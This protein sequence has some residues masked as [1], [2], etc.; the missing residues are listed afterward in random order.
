MYDLVFVVCMYLYFFVFFLV[1]NSFLGNNIFILWNINYP[2][3]VCF[4]IMSFC[5]KVDR[6]AENDFEFVRN[7]AIFRNRIA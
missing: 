4:F 6:E 2:F 5:L 3:P 7:L 1:H